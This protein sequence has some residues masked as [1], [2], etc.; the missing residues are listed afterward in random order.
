MPGQFEALN[1]SIKQHFHGAVLQDFLEN[2]EPAVRY[3]NRWGFSFY[4]RSVPYF[5][6][7]DFP[8]RQDRVIGRVQTN[9]LRHIQWAV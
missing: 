4:L 6:W 2:V 7:G 8:M 3:S 5:H 1:R 9:C